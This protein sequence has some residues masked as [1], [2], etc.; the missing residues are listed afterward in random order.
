MFHDLTYVLQVAT[1]FETSVNL[2]NFQEQ[3]HINISRARNRCTRR[4]EIASWRRVWHTRF[5]GWR[6][7]ATVSVILC[8]L[9]LFVN[10]LLLIIAVAAWHPQDR[11]ATA[12]TGDCEVA[13]RQLT[14]A[15]LCINLLSSMLLGASNYCMQRL[16]APTRGEI[17]AAHSVKE[18]M[19][20]GIPSLRNLFLIARPR[21]LLWL[22]LGLSSIPLHFL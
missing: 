21:A 4:F 22:L 8:A 5:S 18:A 14:V 12:F 10:M 3:N 13:A 17:D 7:G 1:A 16:V 11:I 15:H 19:D 20:I 6:G 2:Q 9:I